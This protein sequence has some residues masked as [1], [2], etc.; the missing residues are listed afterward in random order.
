MFHDTTTH[1][2]TKLFFGKYQQ[3]SFLFIAVPVVKFIAV[4]ANGHK[5]V[6]F[7]FFF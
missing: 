3:N 6:S 1:K 5:N 2:K 4:P 7:F